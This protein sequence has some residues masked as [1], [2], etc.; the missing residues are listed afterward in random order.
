MAKS[1]FLSE[2]KEVSE[3]LVSQELSNGG[4]SFI[5]EGGVYPT[6]VS[7]AFIAQTK[8]GGLALEL[9][10]EGDNAW[11]TTLYIASNKKNP[12]TKQNELVTTFVAK[13]KVQSLGGYKL[14]K[15]LMFLAT[16]KPIDLYSIE[17][18]EAEITY[19]RYGKEVTVEAE[20][21]TDLIGKDIQIAIRQEEQYAYDK[22]AEEEDKTQL[23]VDDDGDIVYNLDLTDVYSK[24]GFSPVEMVKGA[25]EP[26]AIEEKRA[27]LSGDKAIKKVKLELP[28]IEEEEIEDDDS[29]ELGF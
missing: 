22:E 4:M 15:Q 14:F 18:E 24:D 1:K 8:K 20:R 16:G 11:N 2:V 10:F 27:F 3:E 26:K 19:K 17:V 25:E 28:E 29:D 9:F 6:T 12:K 23:R 21:V 7:E 13:G 5:K